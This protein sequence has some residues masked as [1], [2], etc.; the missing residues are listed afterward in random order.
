MSPQNLLLPFIIKLPNQEGETSNSA[1]LAAVV[2]MAESQRK[3]T[4]LLRD[5]PEKIAYLTKIHYP[6][7]VTAAENAAV[8]LD[9]LNGS[10]HRFS[11]RE[12]TK[13]VGFIEELRKNAV[14]PTLFVEA[15]KTQ[16]KAVHESGSQVDLAF[17]AL[18]DDRELLGF[19]QEYFKSG[20]MD[21]PEEANVVVP[22]EIDSKAAAETTQALLNTLRVIQ[23]D[24]KGLQQAL[25]VLKEEAEI[26]KS[27]ASSESE[28][29][30][31]KCEKEIAALKPTVDKNVKKLTQKHDKAAAA[32]QK[33]GDRKVAALEKRRDRFLH[34]LEAAELKR[35]A[36]QRRVDVAKKKK[37]AKSSLGSYELN[38]Y[39]REIEGAKKEVKALSDT[40]DKLKKEAENNIKK[41]DEEF[42]KAVAQEQQ[43]IT[44][45][46]EAYAAKI[47]GKQAE[48][49]EI[50]SQTASLN[51]GFETQIDE[52][53]RD[54]SALRK[55]VKIGYNMVDFEEPV[56]A[57]V[58]IY[59]VKYVK[60]EEERYSLI[61]PLNIA[62]DTGK[63]S[64]L[65]NM[66]SLNSEPKIK[67]MTKPASRALHDTLTASVVGRLEADADFRIRVNA[68]CRANNLLSLNTFLQTL[69]ESLDEMEKK[70]WITAQEASVLCRN[71]SEE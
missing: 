42:E 51:T 65:K 60:A 53:K 35:A 52:L 32:L 62:E 16:A 27:A 36:V 24:A 21:V 67:T 40:I 39:G 1:E 2:C 7:W 22:A 68:V 38:R 43:K 15:L 9:G 23:A 59:L 31:E 47:D 48:I 63:I 55:Q 64:S 61:S 57:L 46:D 13:T 41:L 11:F 20:V 3:K 28:A 71:I 26:H 56:L 44:Q 18:I 37:R 34:K 12:P 8:V 49:D 6:V 33:A 54:A 5:K 70:G 10:G 45:I 14:N 30:K 19:L 66:L 50:N 58:P 17:P 29:L 25:N 69:N 4:S